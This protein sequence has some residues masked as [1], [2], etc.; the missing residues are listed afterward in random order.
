M[1][2]SRRAF[3]KTAAAAGTLSGSIGFPMVSRAQAKTVVVWWNRGYYKEEDEAMIKIAQDFE[4]A[5][6]VKVDI[7]FT[8]QEDLLKKLIA[9]IQ[10]RRVP[11]V[12]FCFYNDW[13]VM[14]NN[15]WTDK[16]TETTDLIQGLSRATTSGSSRW[17][18]A[19]TTWPRSGRITACRSRP[20][21]CTST[22]GGTSSRRRGCRTP[23]TRSRSSGRSTG[24]SG[25][26]RRTPSGRRTPRSTASSSGSA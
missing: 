3:L 15:A 7:S 21:S 16:L 19:T 10:A 22:T 26:R 9:A 25:R 20:R 13:E 8:I 18:T 2:Q 23:P 5:K 12:A 17:P 11:D 4:K 6:G 14:P 24:T 1:A